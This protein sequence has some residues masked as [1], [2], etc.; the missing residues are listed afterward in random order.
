MPSVSHLFVEG[1]PGFPVTE[2]MLSPHQH[3]PA[4]NI[5][6]V[7]QLGSLKPVVFIIF[8]KSAMFTPHS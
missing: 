8:L 4:L 7:D 3:G 5:P 1:G 6:Q 2:A